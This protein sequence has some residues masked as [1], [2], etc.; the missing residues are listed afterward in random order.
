MLKSQAT[1]VEEKMSLALTPKRNFRIVFWTNS[2][3][4]HDLKLNLIKRN[5]KKFLFD[6]D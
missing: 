1:P 5:L 3:I 6:Y 4:M 2:K